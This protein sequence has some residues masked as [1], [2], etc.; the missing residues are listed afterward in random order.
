MVTDADNAHIQGPVGNSVD[1]ESGAS[2]YNYLCVVI[3]SHSCCYQRVNNN[4]L[5]LVCY[6][7]T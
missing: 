4:C 2:D 1:L 6:V 5:C 7:N 3:K